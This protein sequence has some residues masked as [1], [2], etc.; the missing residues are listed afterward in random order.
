[1]LAG[2]LS[3][4]AIGL[5][6]T[7]A[8]LKPSADGLGTHKQLGLP[9][10]GWIATS[11]TPCPTC[12]MTTAFASVAR[13]QILN[14]FRAQPMGALG[15]LSASALFWAGLHVAVFGSRIGASAGRLLTPRVL[16]LIGALWA[17]SW[18]YK[19]LTY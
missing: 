13:G 7:G 6:L 15:A 3:L 11:N 10:C 1:M 4:V 19:V 14:A 12:G 5:L 18:I 16:W 8:A 17:I 2:L 9:S